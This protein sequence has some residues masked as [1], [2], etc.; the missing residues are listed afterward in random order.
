F[1]GPIRYDLVYYHVG[2]ATSSAPDVSF[3][4]AASPPQDGAA[5][6]VNVRLTLH[7]AG[8]QP[9][10]L[11]FPSGQSFDFQILDEHGNVLYQWSKGKAFTLIYRDEIFGPGE[12]TY[13]T[14]VPLADLPP[15]RYVV[16]GYLTTDPVQ[17]SGEVIFEIGPSRTAETVKPPRSVAAR[18]GR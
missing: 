16:R 10:H 17:F 8:P 12:K 14:M 4:V 7:S 2:T 15:G 9:I 6:L 5:A 18:A 11:K 1:A 3:T 13:G